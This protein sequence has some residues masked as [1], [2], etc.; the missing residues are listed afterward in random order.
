M[1]WYEKM[2][3]VDEGSDDTTVINLQKYSSKKLI[4]FREHYQ[5]IWATTRY[6]GCG[7]GVFIGNPEGGEKEIDEELEVKHQFLSR[8]YLNQYLC[9]YYLFIQ[10]ICL[11]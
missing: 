8:Y 6:I 2:F 11:K 3:V 1:Q 9:R 4:A 5:L 10:F 7:R